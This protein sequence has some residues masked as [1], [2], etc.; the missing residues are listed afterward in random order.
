ML[1]FN[2]ETGEQVLGGQGELHL[3]L[4]KWRLEH[5]QKLEPVF[6]SPKVPYRETIRRSAE[7][8]YRHKTDRRCRPVRR[9]APAHEPWSEGMP[10]PEGVNVREWTSTT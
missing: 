4:V 7:A 10:A 5:E 9:G 3:N 8:S 2:R 6:G 1:G